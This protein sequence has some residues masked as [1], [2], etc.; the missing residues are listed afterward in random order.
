MTASLDE[1][2]LRQAKVKARRAG[3]GHKSKMEA[4]GM[5]N[6]AEMGKLMKSVLK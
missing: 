4:G 5:I 1:A 3:R 6:P 2:N